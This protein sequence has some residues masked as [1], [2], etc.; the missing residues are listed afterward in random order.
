M[1]IAEEEDD[2]IPFEEKMAALTQALFE[3][4]SKG[5]K[6][7]VEIRKNLKIFGYEI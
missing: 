6:L 1:G 7:D 2:G 5:E 3:Q 4:M